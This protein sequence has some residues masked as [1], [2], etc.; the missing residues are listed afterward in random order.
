MSAFL[1]FEVTLILGYTLYRTVAC[2]KLEWQCINKSYQRHFD[3]IVQLLT[4]GGVLFATGPTIQKPLYLPSVIVFA[5]SLLAFGAFGEIPF[6]F[7]SL[8]SN[9]S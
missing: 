9:D 5:C 7:N 2:P 1:V 6:M 8:N 3:D 4:I